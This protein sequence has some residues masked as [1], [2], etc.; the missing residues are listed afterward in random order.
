M[1]AAAHLQ[2]SEAELLAEQ[3]R[4]AQ[5]QLSTLTGAVHPDDLLGEIF[6]FILYRE[7]R[8]QSAPRPC[9]LHLASWKDLPDMHT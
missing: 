1:L 6:W 3:L 9:S 8:P 4:L 5:Q 7:V 2:E